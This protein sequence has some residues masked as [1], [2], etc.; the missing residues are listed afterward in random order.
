MEKRDYYEILGIG[1]SANTDEIKQAYRKLALQ[2]HPDRVPQEQKK[3]AEEKF[4]GISEAYAVLSD[5]QKRRQYDQYGHAGIGQRY[6]Y[7]DIFRGA[8]FTDF[9]DIFRSMGSGGFG[10]GFGGFSFTGSDI[11]DS[12]FGGGGARRR[13][14][15]RGRDIEFHVSI[16][17][18]DAAKG[19]EKEIEVP[20]TERCGT[21]GG[22]GAK[23][24][25]KRSQCPRCR[26]T[27]QLRYVR[28]A[29]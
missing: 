3:E 6:S 21:C 8:D 13:G 12:F 17:L 9:S 29:G 24:G 27:G 1:R 7:E 14:P 26:G 5:E 11:F 20:R 10:R 2:F 23:P 4:K 15:P 18:D 16:T 28:Q 22:S 19:A 25:T